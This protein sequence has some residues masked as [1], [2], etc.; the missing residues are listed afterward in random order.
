MIYDLARADGTVSTVNVDRKHAIKYK[1]RECS[2]FDLAS[3][4]GCEFETCQ[5]Y[6]FRFGGLGE[7]SAKDRARAIKKFCL[8]C[9]L[10]STLERRLCPAID[11]DL[12]P[13]RLG[14]VKR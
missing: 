5:L 7:Y 6:P 4:K 1:C 9:C 13:Y 11:C 8:E 14:T 2:G 10:G 12:Y 3:V